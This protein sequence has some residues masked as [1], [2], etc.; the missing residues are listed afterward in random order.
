MVFF[1][2]L[3]EFL[4]YKAILYGVTIIKVNPEYTNQICH[5][6]NILEIRNREEFSCSNNFCNYK[7][8][9]DYNTSQNTKNRGI[10]R[11]KELWVTVIN[12]DESRL[13][14]QI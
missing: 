12:P 7:G 6:C 9:S 5:K 13:N 10:E 3:E 11:L 2:Q 8:H 1:Y 14:Q 4:E